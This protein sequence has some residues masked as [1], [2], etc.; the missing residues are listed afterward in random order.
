M[1]LTPA[2]L[3]DHLYRKP[4]TIFEAMTINITPEITEEVFELDKEKETI[5]EQVDNN[6]NRDYLFPI[7]MIF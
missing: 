5:F 4:L 2:I 6:L 1:N 3:P 7:K